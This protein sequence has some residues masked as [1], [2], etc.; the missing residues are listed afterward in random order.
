MPVVSLWWVVVDHPFTVCRETHVD[1]DLLHR[2]RPALNDRQ[3]EGRSQ[4]SAGLRRGSST[5]SRLLLD[6]GRTA[7][8][9]RQI[10]WPV[11]ETFLKRLHQLL[12]VWTLRD[13]GRHD[14]LT[15]D[16]CS[17]T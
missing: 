1:G 12:D 4:R 7:R 9:L 13:L 6:T 8:S 17:I 15:L 5:G 14:L 11:R 10:L 3:C 2:P 16:L